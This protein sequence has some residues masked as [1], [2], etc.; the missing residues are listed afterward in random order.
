[1]L[2][3]DWLESDLLHNIKVNFFH[4][5][6]SMIDTFYLFYLYILNIFWSPHK[7]IVLASYLYITLKSGRH[8][9]L[10][11]L[12]PFKYY[13][14]SIWKGSGRSLDDQVYLNVASCSKSTTHS[15]PRILFYLFYSLLSCMASIIGKSNFNVRHMF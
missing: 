11:R 13:V 12:H 1:M 7:M 15:C 5:Q 10:M 6:Y 8:S 14:F 3:S 2:E 9:C 4:Y